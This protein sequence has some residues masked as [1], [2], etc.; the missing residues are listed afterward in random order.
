MARK[1]ADPEQ[2]RTETPEPV[3]EFSKYINRDKELRT[4]RMNLIIQPS[5]Y[6]QVKKRA[7]AEGISVNELVIRAMAQYL[8]GGEQ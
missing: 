6:E 1:K 2:I 8:A 4:Q 7:N 5:L 3:I